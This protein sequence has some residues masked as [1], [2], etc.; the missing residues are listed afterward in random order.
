MLV[1]AKKLNDVIDQFGT[2]I[3][4]SE[5]N[6]GRLKISLKAS[7]LGIK[8]W[9]LQFLDHVEIIAPLELREDIKNSLSQNAYIELQYK[10]EQF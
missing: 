7:L 8:Y 3:T 1:N 4:I 2:N 6:D 10:G 9:A 5:N